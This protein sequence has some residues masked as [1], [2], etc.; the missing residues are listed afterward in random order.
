MQPGDKVRCIK[1]IH[2]S[3]I[4]THG[5]TYT[6]KSASGDE[7]RLEGVEHPCGFWAKARFEPLLRYVVVVNGDHLSLEE[8]E[9]EVRSLAKMFLGISITIAEVRSTF[10]AEVTIHESR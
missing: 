10:N 7:L 4:L 1:A 5:E 2:S 3:G 8:A 9:A 6:V